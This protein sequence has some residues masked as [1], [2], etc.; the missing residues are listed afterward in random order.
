MWILISEPCSIHIHV[1]RMQKNLCSSPQS[2]N[3]SFLLQ[4][5]QNVH[6][7]MIKR[8]I[9]PSIRQLVNNNG[10]DWNWSF[11]KSLTLS[12]DITWVWNMDH[13]STNIYPIIFYWTGIKILIFSLV[14]CQIGLN[15][16]FF[17]RIAKFLAIKVWSHES[18]FA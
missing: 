12:V 16:Q 8:K 18:F 10:W 9:L 17:I 6:K 11:S 7:W 15:L 5:I 2:M 14:L 1:T 13:V 4:L 3:V